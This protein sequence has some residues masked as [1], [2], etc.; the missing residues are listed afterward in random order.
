MGRAAPYWFPL[1]LLI[2]PQTLMLARDDWG[3]L[4]GE[5]FDPDAYARL[6]RVQELHDTGAWHS[7]ML[8]RSNAPYGERLHWTRPV[9]MLLLAGAAPL[10][11]FIGFR[12]ALHWSGVFL[13]PALHVLT[14]IALMWSVRPLFRREHLLYGMGVLPLCKSNR[15]MLSDWEFRM[16]S[17]QRSTRVVSLGC[18]QSESY[19]VPERNPPAPSFLLINADQGI[20]AKQM[21]PRGLANLGATLVFSLCRTELF[22]LTVSLQNEAAAYSRPDRL[23]SFVNTGANGAMM[24]ARQ[25]IGDEFGQGV[26]GNPSHGDNPPL[27][28]EN[29]QWRLV[30]AQPILATKGNHGTRP[31]GR[32]MITHNQDQAV[33]VQLPKPLHICYS[34]GSGVAEAVAI[35]MDGC[36]LWRNRKNVRAPGF[37]PQVRIVGR[38]G[39]DKIEDSTAVRH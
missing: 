28:I 10:W 5:L 37:V 32:C 7:T 25:P 27:P 35:T 17:A 38:R 18:R 31:Q 13:S 36:I 29:H 3:P 33:R 12:S 26:M 34:G 11:P 6:I 8:P 14:L 22:A 23:V 4:R 24:P 39:E 21:G 15:I 19:R 9:D 1:I 2:L 16:D 20:Y 30:T